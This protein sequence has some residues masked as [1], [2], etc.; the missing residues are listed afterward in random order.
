[1]SRDMSSSASTARPLTLT[2][3]LE[4][5]EQSITLTLQEIDHNFSRAHQ[6]VTTSILPVVERYGEQSQAV[7]EGSKFWKQFFEASANVSLSGYEDR[8][9]GV[10]TAGPEQEQAEDEEEEGTEATVTADSERPQDEGD[11]KETEDD[12]EDEDE[13]ED[14][15]ATVTTTEQATTDRLEPSSEDDGDDGA[16]VDSLL[17][18][19]SI[20]KSTPRTGPVSGSKEPT[21]AAT[22]GKQP[23]QTRHT[24]APT[25]TFAPYGSP[26]ETLRQEHQ[27]LGTRADANPTRTTTAHASTAGTGRAISQ[28]ARLQRPGRAGG[29]KSRGKDRLLHRVLDKTYR[30]QATPH[31]TPTS[32]IPRPRHHLTAAPAHHPRLVLQPR[33]PRPDDDDD[34]SPQS[35]P[36][37]PRPQLHADLFS[38]VTRRTLA[39]T[40][41]P[42]ARKLQPGLSVLHT[43]RTIGYGGGGDHD[44]GDDDDAGAADDDDLDE[45]NDYPYLT[46]PPKT[47]QF[48][49]PPNQL[50]RTPAKE[51]S[52]R[53]VRDLLHTAGARD[54]ADHDDFRLAPD[55][56][57]RGDETNETNDEDDEDEP[58]PAAL[59]LARRLSRSR[60]YDGV[61]VDVDVDVH[62]HEH[63]DGD[64]DETTA[65]AEDGLAVMMM[66]DA[67]SPSPVVRGRRAEK[68]S[69]ERF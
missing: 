38:P 22:T 40:P 30:I 35:S 27:P 1:M 45:S 39:A 15:D 58:T 62:V 28:I 66:M 52:R 17:D 60:L 26:Y 64:Q 48:A 57:Y 18:S 37:V 49:I 29:E 47:I 61:D 20:S 5:L 55:V 13:D 9:S 42:K 43:P 2:E 14:Y 59:L 24:T 23:S 7:W 41:K 54:G 34:E 36:D 21:T 12:D 46:S 51:A 63:G 50:L 4:K 67:A 3:E 65:G 25:A 53:I 10:E 44:E 8:A 68:G 32:G 56:T 69:G 6:I 16:Q 19:P 33:P 11:E 31:K